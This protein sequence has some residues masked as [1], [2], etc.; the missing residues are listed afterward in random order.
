VTGRR[1]PAAL[2]V[3]ALL[4]AGVGC[5]PSLG[6]LPDGQPGNGPGY[7]VT[8]VFADALNLTIGAEVRRNG[9]L[10][11]RV[12]S[13]TTRD[14]HADAVLR[15]AA[16]TVLPGGTNAQIRF[17]TPLGEDY[18][19]LRGGVPGRPPVAPGATIGPADTST[20]PTIEDTFAALSLVL[21]GG[22]ID[23][24]H[25][26]VTAIGTA[27]SGREAQARDLLPRLDQ[28]ATT[29]A[30]SRGDIDRLITGLGTL[31]GR[32]AGG[33][34]VSRALTELP[35]A[36]QVVTAQTQALTDLLGKVDALGR[37]TA[38]VLGR[39]TD[40]L[41]ADIN[42]AQPILAALSGVQ[43][44]FAEV[45]ADVQAF[46]TAFEAASKGQYLGAAETAT[47]QLVQGGGAATS[48]SAQPGTG[49]GAITGLLG[50]PPLGGTP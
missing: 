46:G 10:V 36:L 11:G 43:Q 35:A 48:S 20:A 41:V 18:V 33:D 38:D 7:R 8:A 9:V 17:T 24:L 30:A 44:R 21:N 15:L 27:L 31:A 6:M 47:L 16:G 23:Q 32:F 29:L 34:V 45:L 19:D 50:L 28:L 22:G 39:S 26:I 37:T 49:L 12:E 2:G 14:Y 42:G 40:N 4:V 13:L 1:L 25:T 5:R 3:A